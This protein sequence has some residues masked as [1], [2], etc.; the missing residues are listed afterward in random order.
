PQ[1]K[2]VHFKLTDSKEYID[3]LVKNPHASP[4]KSMADPSLPLSPKEAG[5]LI[6]AKASLQ[7]SRPEACKRG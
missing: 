2:K 1:S 5:G 7:R 3:I 6:K 4:P